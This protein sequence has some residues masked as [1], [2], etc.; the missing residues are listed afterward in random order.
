MAGCGQRSHFGQLA[1]ADQRGGVGPLTALQQNI[2]D[3]RTGA[4][5]QLAELVD[6]GLK[7]IASDG[8][9]CGT[10]ARFRFA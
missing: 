3:L 4:G 6:L 5:G 8:I 7:V 9:A 10:A 1:F 2:D